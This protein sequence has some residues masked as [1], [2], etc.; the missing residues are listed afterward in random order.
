M[1]ARS[2]RQP[3][4]ARTPGQASGAAA[5]F[6]ELYRAV[7]PALYAWAACN[8]HAP[9]RASIDPEDVL[10][11][12]A[13]RAYENYAGF[14]ERRGNFRG[15]IFGIARRV[16]YQAMER[17]RSSGT[18]AAR[19]QIETG[20]LGSLPDTATSITAAIA[21]DEQITAFLEAV[22]E[23]PRDDRQLLVYR[24]LEGL[25]HKEVAELMN[26]SPEAAMQRWSRLRARL[27]ENHLRLDFVA[28]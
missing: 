14:D 5:G 26:L 16:L 2:D 13:C 17:L 21:R 7:A 10:Q 9:L 20:S 12:V 3:S 1:D 11:E 8:L 24:G 27:K 22:D 23:L 25:S 4:A 19:P 15:W 28:A 18:P 6:V